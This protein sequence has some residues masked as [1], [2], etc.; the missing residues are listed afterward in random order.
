LDPS[1]NPN[2]GALIA[3]LAADDHVREQA[4]VFLGHTTQEVDDAL[5]RRI[6]DAC[7]Q[8][9]ADAR[10]CFAVRNLAPHEATF[11][12][13]GDD[14]VRH[15]DGAREVSLFVV[16]L[17]LAVD[18]RLRLLSSVDPVG[19]VVYDAVA[20]A[21]VERLADA[22][23][24][25]LRARIRGRGLHPSWRFSPGYGDLPLSVQPQLLAAVDATRLCGVTLTSSYLMVPTKSV[26]AIV[27]AHEVPQPGIADSC[28]LCAL[29]E[30]CG[31]R[32]RGVT[33]RGGRMS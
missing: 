1:A 26:S 33:C 22:V 13:R 17:G 7:S 24:A 21:A 25:W 23:E 19:Q 14:I 8:V 16:T 4:L 2:L 15:L 11:L 6:D 28:A 5:Y 9:S 27:G 32:L 30:V 20:S 18:R 31:M 3:S 10:A 12:M 29:V